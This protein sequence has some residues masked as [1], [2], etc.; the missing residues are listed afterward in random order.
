MYPRTPTMSPRSRAF[1]SAKRVFADFVLANV[2]LEA[3]G[4]IV[5]I[6]EDGF[7]HLALRHHA[8]GEVPGFGLR[9]FS[10]FEKAVA[11]ESSAA[12]ASTS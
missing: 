7:A 6:G 5:E 10:V 11:R 3:P 8:P 4:A 12:V 9:G 1:Q 2:E